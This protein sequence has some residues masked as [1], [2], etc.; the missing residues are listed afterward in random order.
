[1]WHQWCVE[2]QHTSH[3]WL[4]LDRVWNQL[5]HLTG[6]S[7]CEITGCEHKCR[8]KEMSSGI[9]MCT[10]YCTRTLGHA[11]I[12][13]K[14]SNAQRRFT[15]VKLFSSRILM[16]SCAHQVTMQLSWCA[17]DDLAVS[18]RKSFSSCLSLWR[19]H[20]LIHPQCLV[21]ALARDSKKPWSLKSFTAE[22]SQ[23]ERE[24]KK[25]DRPKRRLCVL[26]DWLCQRG[27]LLEDGEGLVEELGGVGGWEM[28]RDVNYSFRAGEVY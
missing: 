4:H 15:V 17:I 10:A 19:R 11:T 5:K 8:H 24:E 2:T 20:C 9:L 21:S 3:P 16:E 23:S 12:S 14:M 25:L 1:M 27:F 18:N 26:F 6:H 7:R 28:G 22:V 13:Q